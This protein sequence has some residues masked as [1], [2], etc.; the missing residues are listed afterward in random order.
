M[1]SQGVFS[2]TQFAS[3]SGSIRVLYQTINGK[4]HVRALNIQAVDADGDDIGITLREL[5]TISVP[6]TSGSNELTTL[7]V[8]SISEKPQNFAGVPYYFM[9]VE[10]VTLN[11]I[12][13]SEG[14]IIGI[15]PYLSQP[16]FYNNY[17]ALISN[18]ESPKLSSLRY[19]VDRTAGQVK[20]QNY[21]A[22][23]G[24]GSILISDLAY[25]NAAGELLD[26]LETG[27]YSAG[28]FIA[29]IS[30]SAISTPT[31]RDFNLTVTDSD[32]KAALGNPQ[33][34]TLSVPPATYDNANYYLA[35]S[36]SLLI[37]IDDN[38]DFDNSNNHLVSGAIAN[39]TYSNGTIN[40]SYTPY[41]QRVPSGSFTSGLLY[42]RL[43]QTNQ[44]ITT[45]DTSIPLTL[46]SI[47]N[48]NPSSLEYLHISLKYD[49]QQPYAAYAPVQDSNYTDTGL[50]NARYNGTK[51]G[52]DDFSG[53]TPAVAAKP[54]D[55]AIY[56]SDE[57]G[58]FICSQSLADRDMTTVLFDGPTEYPTAAVTVLGR[59]N[60]PVTSSA[61]PYTVN[62]EGLFNKQPQP[63]DI[64]SIQSEKMQ[65]LN[66]TRVYQGASKAPFYDLLVNRGVQNTSIIANH[67]LDYSVFRLSGA[68]I[69][70]IEGSRLIAVSD[71]KLWIKDNRNV[72]KTNDRG[73]VIEIDEVCTV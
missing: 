60:T 63:G 15:S 66:V 55:A 72:I 34:S 24:D 7:R 8:L 47:L 46:T 50:I 61:S 41:K 53:I 28:D 65:V 71:K 39:Q 73:F 43:R 31:N 59:V 6:I 12:T 10:D 36:S 30:S 17:N 67:P 33:I 4:D 51:T 45:Q 21:D 40:Y 2:N 25:K 56:R 52:E 37:E 29:P 62:I 22:L 48:N 14:S 64:I 49:D 27:S 3:P 9:D 23:S 20:P 58:S 44:V 1:P 5:E 68:R 18:A 54:I 35:A 69:L 19:D 26:S 11:N 13:G 70:T 16:F 32:I 38:P 57:S 42:A